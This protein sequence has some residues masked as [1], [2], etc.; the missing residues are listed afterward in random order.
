ME[1]GLVEKELIGDRETYVDV[2][3]I[4]GE[5]ARVFKA[6]TATTTETEVDRSKRFGDQLRIRK[7]QAVRRERKIENMDR[8]DSQGSVLASG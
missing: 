4:K 8:I 7:G 2:L 1:D 3:M 6:I 5:K